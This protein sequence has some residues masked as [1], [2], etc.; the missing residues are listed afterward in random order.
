MA[1]QINTGE[2]AKA[3][4]KVEYKVPI[5]EVSENHR[6]IPKAVFVEDVEA[7]VEQ[8][9]EDIIFEEMNTLY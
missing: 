9:G 6:R 1:Q 4:P 8:Y 3:V 2:E 7:W 5:T